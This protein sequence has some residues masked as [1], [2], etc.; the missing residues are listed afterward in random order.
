MAR[1]WSSTTFALLG[2]F[3]A[4]YA[5]YIEYKKTLDPGYEALC[6]TQSFSCTAVLMSAY[7]H[8]LSKWG[9]VAEG[10]AWDV[11]NPILGLAFYGLVLLRKPLGLPRA[12]VFAASLGSCLFSLYLAGV[13]YW[14]LRDFCVVCVSSYVCNFAI[15]AIELSA[16]LDADGRG[17]LSVGASAS[18]GGGG[19]PAGKA[20]GA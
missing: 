13:L 1:L 16:A 19:G 12:L 7:G 5:L 2:I 14:V 18:R 4:L 17:A 8:I 11:P 20:K 6:D 3:V 15:F 10:S 9:I